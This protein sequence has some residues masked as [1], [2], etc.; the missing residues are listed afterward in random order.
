MK[1]EQVL[2]YAGGAFLIYKFFLAPKT[3]AIPTQA[4]PIYTG[5]SN[6]PAAGNTGGIVALGTGL[7]TTIANLL[8]PKPAAGSTP[9]AAA[10][11][12]SSGAAQTSSNIDDEVSDIFGSGF[13]NPVPVTSS[14]ITS[15]S[16][17]PAASGG[18]LDFGSPLASSGNSAANNFGLPTSFDAG[19]LDDDD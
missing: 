17:A 5:Q 10:A 8:N 18:L 15:L 16:P 6:I 1:T 3:M 2:L 4:T 9:A 14:P 13:S 12:A 11:A 19:S 7:A